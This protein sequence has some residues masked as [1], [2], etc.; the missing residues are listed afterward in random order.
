MYY[1]HMDSPIGRLLLAGDADGLKLI[2]FPQES[3]AQWEQYRDRVFEA[4]AVEWL[5]KQGIRYESD[6]AKAA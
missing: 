4:I 2:R 3:Q 1:T 6:R 5:D